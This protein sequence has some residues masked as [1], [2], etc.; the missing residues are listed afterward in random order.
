MDIKLSIKNELKHIIQLIVSGNYAEVE[1]YTNNIR[2]TADE[3]QECI[4][5]YGCKIVFPPDSAFED[6]DIIEVNASTQK[7]WSVRFTLWTEEEGKSDLS[8]DMFMNVGKDENL[9]LE[10]YNIVVF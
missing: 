8:L 3:V 7:E 9:R 4:E 1:N 10:L 2:M 6:L 5:D